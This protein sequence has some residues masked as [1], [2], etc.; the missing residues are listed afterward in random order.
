MV[1]VKS[2]N[3]VGCGRLGTVLG[4]LLVKSHCCSIK[5]VLNRTLQSSINAVGMLGQGNSYE[6]VESL[7]PADITLIAS[8]DRQLESL[9]TELVSCGK[10]EEGSLLFHCSGSLSSQ[11]FRVAERTGVL[12]ASIHPNWSFSD[13]SMELKGFE[14]IWC[15]LEGG[16]EAC[17]IL[18]GIFQRIG[19][20]VFHLKSSKKVLYHAASVIACNY[21]NTLL[22]LADQL[23]RKSGIPHDEALHLMEPLVRGTLD[24]FFEKGAIASLTGPISRGDDATLELHLKELESLDPDLVNLY[25]VMGLKTVDLTAKGGNH[26]MDVIKLMR[27]RLKI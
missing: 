10:L 1:K 19:A 23:Y 4:R 18:E 9:A 7:E 15:G 22:E 8:P 20:R 13:P 12:T 6:S 21:L 27:E 25:K 26:P 11:I 17:D 24:N 16:R 2:I 3:I 5:G 14:G